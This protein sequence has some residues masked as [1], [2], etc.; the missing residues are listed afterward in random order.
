M[1]KRRIWIM[2]FFILLSFTNIGCNKKHTHQWSEATCELPMTCTICHETKGEALGHNWVDATCTLPKTCTKCGA[3]EEEAL[4]HDWVDA[5]CT[6][7]KTCAKCG[8]T[9]GKALGHDWVDATYDAPKTCTRCG[10]TEGE[11]LIAL[12][13]SLSTPYISVGERTILS[14][15]NY[16]DLY[17]FNIEYSDDHVISMDNWGFITGLKIGK[18]TIT[19]TSKNNPT[20]KGSIDIEV[21]GKK[22]EA[23]VTSP[24]IAL[25]DSTFIFFKNTDDLV[26]KS[27]DDFNI[28][29]KKG[30]ILIFDTIDKKLHAIGFGMETI[31]L[32]SKLDERITTTIDIDVVNPSS[33]VILHGKDDSGIVKAG[34]QFQFTI[35]DNIETHTNLKWVSSDQNIAVITDRGY[36]A[37][38]KEGIVTITV[39]D[40]NDP[41]NTMKKTN[42]VITVIGETEADYISRFIHMALR[43]D[44]V[45]E[46]GDNYQKFGEWYPNNGQPWCATFV[47]WCWYH[48]GLSYDIL[49]KYQGCYTGMKWCTEKGIMHFVQNYTFNEELE[50][51]VSSIQYAT[52]YKPQ[53]GD[54]VFF[55]SSDMSHTGIVIYSDDLYVYTIEGNTSDQVDIKRW[56]I[57]DARITGYAH[58]EYPSYSGVREDF[59]WIALPKEDGTNWWTI[60][61]EHQKVD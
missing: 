11:A 25:N 41:Q 35:V 61:S 16:F 1:R 49:C 32:T 36:V 4:G 28:S 30:N 45:H 12:H 33:F 5:T 19:L 22:P 18:T 10:A 53:T 31:T 9:E 7:P 26:E 51:N 34:E 58:P 59:S 54:I 55:L 38:K 13:L 46:T 21:I 43:E 17:E 52:D 3:T 24:R 14:V 50:N 27:I 37:L 8:A 23:Y 42:Y 2:I 48:S 29:F 15:E 47:S 57:N 20:I 60:V 6:L 44:G 39:Y 40:P 56:S